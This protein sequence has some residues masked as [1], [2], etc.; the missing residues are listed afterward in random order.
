MGKR[1]ARRISFRTPF[2]FFAFLLVS[3]GPLAAQSL[4]P[5]SPTPLAVGE[6]RGTLNSMVGP[7]YWSFKYKKEKGNVDVRFTSMG[8]LGN[9]MTTTIQVVFHTANGQVLES[10]A[11]TSKGSVAELNFPATFSGPGTIVVEL[12]ANTS[13]LVRVGG[14]YTVMLSGDAIDFSSAVASGKDRIAGT[15]TVMV[16][17]PDFDCRGGLAIRFLPDGTVQTADG[18]SGTWKLFDPDSL[19]YSVAVGTDRWSLKLIPGRGLFSPNDL[20]TPVFQAVR[21]K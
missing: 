11:L 4:D 15:Y 2:V 19:V 17:P 10:R 6:N 13:S 1:S 14:D 7:Q 21:P 5:K 16:C 9:P 3:F 12:R 20:G 8:V 18:H